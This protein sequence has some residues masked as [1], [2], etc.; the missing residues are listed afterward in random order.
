MNYWVAVKRQL[1]R[2]KRETADVQLDPSHA[3]APE[4][5]DFSKVTSVTMETF[6]QGE[7]TPFH[8]A[9]HINLCDYPD[10]HF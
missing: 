8:L 10:T 9:I 4:R 3:F 1:L 6:N 2:V 7:W 5:L